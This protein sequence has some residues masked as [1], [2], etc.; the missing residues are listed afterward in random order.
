MPPAPVVAY[1]GDGAGGGA[2]VLGGVLLAGRE[3]GRNSRNR[4]DVRPVHPLQ[5]HP[6]IGRE[7]LDVAPLPLGV[8]RVED[9]AGLARARH[10][11]HHDQLVMWQVERDTFEIVGTRP[12][13][14]D[15]A[16]YAAQCVSLV[17]WTRLVA[18]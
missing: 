8:E 7:T 1:L 2:R 4:I 17:P 14:T 13:D 12:A 3:R 15:G 6:G 16:L 11:R 10:S 9:Q 5:E 18:D